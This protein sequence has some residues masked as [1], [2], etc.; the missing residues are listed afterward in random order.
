MKTRGTRR[1]LSLQVLVILSMVIA[2]ANA[3]VTAHVVR[4]QDSTYHGPPQ[5][6]PLGRCMWQK[7]EVSH[8]TQGGG[9]FLAA[10]WSKMDQFSPHDCFA[11]YLVPQGNLMTQLQYYRASS[12]GSTDQLCYSSGATYNQNNDVYEHRLR[13]DQ[14]LHPK[15]NGS[16]YADYYRTRAFGQMWHNPNWV[17]GYFWS[18]L[19]GVH[20]LPTT[21]G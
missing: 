20:Y 6:G 19:P 1:N 5:W 18:G 2:L 14:G 4:D 16:N 13:Y 9:Y 21:P 17:G 10:T 3:P 8:G 7:A 12:T 15:C 11:K